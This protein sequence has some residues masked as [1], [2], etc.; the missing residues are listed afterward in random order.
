MFELEK[1]RQLA[2]FL[3]PEGIENMGVCVRFPQFPTR[4]RNEP[5]M[6]ALLYIRGYVF[7]SQKSV[8]MGTVFSAPEMR[9]GPAR[10][11]RSVH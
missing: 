6:G 8:P 3:G 2:E 7:Y 5:M 11:D 10:I 1:V 9:T 4:S